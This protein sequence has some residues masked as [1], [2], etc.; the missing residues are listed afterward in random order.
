MQHMRRP[1]PESE[2]RQTNGGQV[3]RAIALCAL[4][5]CGVNAFGLDGSDLNRWRGSRQGWWLSEES[6]GASNTAMVAR[7]KGS[8][9]ATEV[10]SEPRFHFN[11]MSN[12]ASLLC[13]GMISGGSQGLCFDGNVFYWVSGS[14]LSNPL[15][16]VFSTSGAGTVLTNFVL[17]GAG[18]GNDLAWWGAADNPMGTNAI[19][20]SS[21]NLSG[22]NGNLDAF[23]TNGVF[24]ARW[25]IG[26]IGSLTNIA[27]AAHLA[28]NQFVITELDLPSRYRIA[29]AYL[30][31]VR[32][33]TGDCTVAWIE[34]LS[35]HIGI[36]S[37]GSCG[38]NGHAFVLYDLNGV[39]QGNT[40]CV[41]DFAIASS[42]CS[43]ASIFL[44]GVP[45]QMENE[46]MTWYKGQLAV[47]NYGAGC[48]NTI[49][50]LCWP[51]T[52]KH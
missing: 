44:C 7:S 9:T 21:G 5:L 42:G 30:G 36:H 22:T 40:V 16:Q 13:T 33:G 20:V 6:F 26:A 35:P 32:A 2:V 31:P 8:S 11:G 14:T 10:P 15:C 41:Y 52:V 27:C 29:L 18:H 12:P 17:T 34:N 3:R 50:L 51:M 48:T 19:L 47:G 28:S 25:D 37:Q 39:D 23:T 4:C 46:G 1:R 45:A 49:R 43:I 24:L 38:T